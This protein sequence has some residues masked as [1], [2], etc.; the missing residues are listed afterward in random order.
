MNVGGKL[1]ENKKTQKSVD[2]KEQP[3]KFLDIKTNNPTTKRQKKKKYII[4]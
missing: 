2:G 1:I 4:G 3:N